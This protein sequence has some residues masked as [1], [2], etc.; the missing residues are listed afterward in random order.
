MEN[1]TLDLTVED[2]NAILSTLSKHPFESIAALIQKIQDQ[3]R[4]Q[5]EAMQAT[6]TEEM[7]ED[8]ESDAG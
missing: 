6:Q 2:T 8:T 1:I 4:A 7:P 3:G 5:I